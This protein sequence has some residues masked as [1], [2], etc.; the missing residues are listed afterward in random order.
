MCDEH[1]D[2][3]DLWIDERTLV[4]VT[5]VNE[6][7][8]LSSMNFGSPWAESLSSQ[9]LFGEVKLSERKVIL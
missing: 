5:K 8:S 9:T 4:M 2:C 7:C 1:A 6:D 3:G